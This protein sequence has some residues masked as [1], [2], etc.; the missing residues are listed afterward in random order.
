MAT[1]E[2]R[3]VSRGRGEQGVS[4]PLVLFLFLIC[5]V[6][7]S[8]VLT[9]ATTAS[10]RATNLYEDDRLYYSAAS[11][12]AVLK[13]EIDGQETKLT[14]QKIGTGD[15]AIY[16]LYLGEGADTPIDSYTDLSLLQ[17]A[18]IASLTGVDPEASSIGSADIK[19][20]FYD[21]IGYDYSKLDDK[22]E[23]E[24]RSFSLG[25]IEVNL[26]D[27]SLDSEVPKATIDAKASTDGSLTLTITAGDPGSGPSSTQTLYFIS[28]ISQGD[29]IEEGSGDGKTLTQVVSVI[30]ESSVYGSEV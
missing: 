27:G 24:T 12:A 16:K 29:L 13:G 8:I 19:D 20:I 10:G 5:A 23:G 1:Y 28:A 7:A 11:A 17:W 15:S 22:P 26:E 25:D 14:F 21:G 4:M 18:A 6:A 9:A 30:W 2:G 3:G